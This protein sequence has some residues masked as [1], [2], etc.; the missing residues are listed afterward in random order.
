MQRII[1]LKLSHAIFVSIMGISF[2]SASAQNVGSFLSN[3]L[4]GASNN[5]AQTDGGTSDIVNLLKIDENLQWHSNQYETPCTDSTTNRF[6][7]EISQLK[8]RGA[9]TEV[10]IQANSMVG[11]FSHCALHSLDQNKSKRFADLSF[12]KWV[13][14]VGMLQANEVIYEG[15]GQGQYRKSAERA[16]QYLDFAKSNGV[17]DGQGLLDKLNQ[18]FFAN[19]KPAN[20]EGKPTVSAPAES[21]VSQHKSNSFG[22]D[23]KYKGK[24]I[25]SSG[26]VSKITSDGKTVSL[27]GAHNKSVDEIGY[28]DYVHC[29]VQDDATLDKVANL[30]KAKKIK[31]RGVYNP[32]QGWMPGLLTLTS[33]K[34]SFN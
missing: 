18:N 20:T 27:L 2:Q 34:I 4:G 29:L 28:N 14:L 22:F 13:A 6:L 16:R 10:Y 23:R 11:F 12:P 15:S 21:L 19:D 5:N 33:C 32:E 26:V 8:Q 9:Q 7:K 30:S 3:L 25:E 24:L 17:N 31:V 1:V